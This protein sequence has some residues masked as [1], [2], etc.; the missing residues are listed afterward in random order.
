MTSKDIVKETELAPRTVRYALKWL[1]AEG[2]VTRT[3][4][5]SDLRQT[6]FMVHTYQRMAISPR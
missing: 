2:V 3:P 6:L 5:L 4:N 1:V